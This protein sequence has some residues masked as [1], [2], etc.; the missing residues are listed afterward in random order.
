MKIITIITLL[1]FMAPLQAESLKNVEAGVVKT[2]KQNLR[3]VQEENMDLMM[4]TIHKKSPAYMSTRYAMEPIFRDYDL[5]YELVSHKFI[6]HDGDLAYIRVVQKTSK[7]NGPAFRNNIIDMVQGYRK[8]A[9][10]WKVWGQFI[11][12]IQYFE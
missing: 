4:S 8:E 9:G 7:I 12:D 2:L 3:S 10:V 11:V 6:A 5:K 1:L